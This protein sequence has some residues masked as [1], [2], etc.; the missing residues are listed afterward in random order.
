MQILQQEGCDN[1]QL[2][3]RLT[4]GVTVASRKARLSARAF[5]IGRDNAYRM[6]LTVEFEDDVI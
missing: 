1:S 4:L 3:A 6:L 5:K 2:R